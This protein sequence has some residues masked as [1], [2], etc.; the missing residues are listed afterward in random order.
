MQACRE[1]AAS[2][3]RVTYIRISKE[4]G[5]AGIAGIGINVCVCVG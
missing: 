3:N 5:I 1:E 2:I 4:V